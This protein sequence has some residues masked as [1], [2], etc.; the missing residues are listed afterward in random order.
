MRV[1]LLVMMMMSCLAA[2]CDEESGSPADSGWV[3][4]YSGWDW[5]RAD[6]GKVDRGVPDV[7]AADKGKAD[8]P[9][10]DVH[11]EDLAPL[12]IS[13]QADAAP[14]SCTGIKK[15]VT[16]EIA[17]IAKCAAT[18][19]CTFLWGVCPFGCHIPHNKSADLAKYKAALA[20]F[21][22]SP[23]CQKCTYKCTAPGALACTAGECVMIYP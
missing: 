17:R 19:Q 14:A 5:A 8:M 22:A 11:V 16:D 4:D 18:S 6:Q 9:V 15:A 10:A 23:L 1:M 12:D 21:Q 13:S 7:S 2:G 20:A 3:Q